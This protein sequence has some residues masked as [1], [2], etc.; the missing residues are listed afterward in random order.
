MG[1]KYEQL[2][3]GYKSFMSHRGGT[4]RHCKRVRRRAMRRLDRMTLLNDDTP[5]RLPFNRYQGWVS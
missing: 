1:A 3:K 2:D 5:S 4:A